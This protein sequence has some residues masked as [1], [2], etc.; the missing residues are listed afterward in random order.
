MKQLTA[1]VMANPIGAV[2]GGVAFYWAS[3]KYAGVS[4][5]YARIGLGIVGLYVGAMAQKAISAQMS[6]PTANTT[7]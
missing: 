2:V 1:P 3:S 5:M 4:N 7:K 6:K